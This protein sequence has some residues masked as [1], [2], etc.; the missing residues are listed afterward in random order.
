[1]PDAERSA[2]LSVTVDGN[3]YDCDGV[4]IIRVGFS[5]KK[6]ELLRFKDYEFWDTVKRKLL[7]DTAGGSCASNGLREADG[8]KADGRRKRR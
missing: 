6:V 2:A 1:V 4:R 3:E 5:K 8:R 7:G